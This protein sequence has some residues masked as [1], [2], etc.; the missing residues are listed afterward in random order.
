MGY[1]P[2]STMVM[3]HCPVIENMRR[4][5]LKFDDDGINDEANRMLTNFSAI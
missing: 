4:I 3:Y 5:L 2:D 1:V